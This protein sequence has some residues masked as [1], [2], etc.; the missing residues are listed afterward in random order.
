[1]IAARIAMRRKAEELDRAAKIAAQEGMF[2]TGT[3]LRNQATGIR[4]AIDILEEDAKLGAKLTEVE[5]LV[6]G[7][8]R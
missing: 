2:E 7:G 8:G 3:A 5:C 1:M 4:M 6:K